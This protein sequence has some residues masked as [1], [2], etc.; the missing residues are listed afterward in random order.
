MASNED[1]R[2]GGKESLAALN[3][4]YR[5]NH[6]RRDWLEADIS[7][8]K[9]VQPSPTQVPV[10]LRDAIRVALAQVFPMLCQPVADR[11]AEGKRTEPDGSEEEGSGNGERRQTK[12]MEGMAPAGT[13][14]DGA[15]SNREHVWEAR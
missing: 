9:I 7:E 2:T 12:D 14:G 4:A 3:I 10:L 1:V 13:G 5:D 6:D 8:S 15:G 11:Q